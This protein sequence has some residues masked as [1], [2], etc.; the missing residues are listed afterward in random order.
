MEEK[1]LLEIAREEINCVDREMA[2]LFERRMR[3]VAQVAKYKQETGMPI[4]DPVREEEILRRGALRVED[5]VIR[6]YYVNFLHANMDISKT[7]QSRLLGGMRVAYSGVKGAFA[8]IAA[9][10]IFPD[11]E[12]CG[13]PDFAAAYRAVEN[14]ESDVAVLPLENSTGGDVGTVMDL[15]FFGSLHINGIYDIEVVQNLLV[16]PGTSLSDVR[17]VIS[18]PQALG[19]CDAFI[20]K[21]GAQTHNAVNTA[22]AAKTV[23]ESSDPSLAAIGSEEAAAEFGLS[24]L[25]SHIQE[26]G[27]NTTRFAVFSRTEKD[28]TER[29]RQFVLLFTV[30][31]EAG[32]LAKA[33][34]AIGD[35]GFNL[36][37]IKSRPTKHLSWEYYFFCEGEGFIRGEEGKK[38]LAELGKNCNDLKVLG[39]FEKEI[40]LS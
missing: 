38:M 22:V 27:G 12:V 32:A 19:Q 20:K 6:G 1:S 2:K 11:A 23:A 30:K 8:Q 34:S 39:A 35:G 25:C 21:I 36:R 26:K 29:D 24:V 9:S 37:A 13:Y 15:A 17:A 5:Q 40:V 4:F 31:N 33:V 16:K 14:G 10:R 28:L 18:H 3:A 7:Y